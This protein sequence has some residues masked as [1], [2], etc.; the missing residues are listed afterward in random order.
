MGVLGLPSGCAKLPDA[1]VTIRF[2]NET[3]TQC[4]RL[5]VRNS[6][7]TTIATRP[8]TIDRGGRDELK[9]GIAQNTDDLKGVLSV[10][11]FRH[12][13]TGC[14]DT[15]FDSASKEL[16]LVAGGTSLEFV[17]EGP[18]G[19]GGM[20]GGADAGADAGT[21]D[22]GACTAPPECHGAAIGCEDDG[23]CRYAV[24]TNTKCDGGVC[25][26]GGVCTADV[27][28]VSAPGST[29]DD[30]L[31]CTSVSQ[32]SDAGTCV[33]TCDFAACGDPVEPITCRADMRCEYTPARHGGVCPLTNGRCFD[34]GCQEWFSYPPANFPN[35]VTFLSAWPTVAW[36]L[37]AGM[38]DAGCTAIVDT[39]G[40]APGPRAGAWCG[41][42]VPA[43]RVVATDAG[44]VALFELAGLD[45]PAGVRLQFA[46]SRPAALLVLG[47]VR[48]EGI[49]S[50]GAM[51][52]GELPAGVDGIACRAASAGTDK[53]GG[54][55]GGFVGKGGN[56]AE[57]G[58]AMG[59]A[60]FYN[61]NGGYPL[62][63]GCS[64]AG[65]V[66]NPDAGGWGGG[67]LQISARGALIV[68]GGVIT[69]SGAGGLGGMGLGSG[70]CPGG[71]GGGSGGLL[72][73]EAKSLVLTNAALTTNGGAGGQGG[74]STTDGGT[75]SNGSL[76]TGVEAQGVTLAGQG[77]AGGNGA[78]GSTTNGSNGATGGGSA[79]G[80][81]GGGAV[82][83][84]H[85]RTDSC[86]KVNTVVSGNLKQISVVCP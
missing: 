44:E 34:G 61:M 55:G 60:A 11:V 53:G 73:L 58:N 80:G 52:P 29:C 78:A 9:I 72:V 81:A 64:G 85:L 50:A 83:Q 67:G 28:S 47:D 33:G 26:A 46:G 43:G 75:G 31:A 63:G 5:T 42:V 14:T 27:C 82:G 25:S 8:N 20:D 38:D 77:G 36:A 7:G 18:G 10:T 66:L 86:T 22:L 40:G 21:C 49:V 59:G 35:D 54:G 62:R 30:G 48:V 68:D 74:S 17:F 41:S 24:L 51:L 45:V 79:G 4:V 32:C 65:N 13:A 56:G 2:V 16:T 39:S 84:I 69:A 1:L 3:R 12:A 76:T 57:S 37:D 23:G 15:A 6:N 19:D 71:G 70:N